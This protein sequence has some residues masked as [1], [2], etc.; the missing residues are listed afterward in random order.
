MRDGE[1]PPSGAVPTEPTATVTRVLWN[2][3]TGSQL[4]ELLYGLLEAMGA[5]SVTWRAGSA[6]GVTAADGGRDLEAIFD[7]PSPDGELDRQKWWVECKGRTETVER[8]CPAS[9]PGRQRS[10]RDRH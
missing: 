1:R 2:G 9:S 5:S 7:R 3:V 4:E 8:C 6:T 10:R